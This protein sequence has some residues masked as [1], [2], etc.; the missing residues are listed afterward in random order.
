MLHETAHLHARFL[1]AQ[2]AAVHGHRH[3]HLRSRTGWLG[4]GC[5]NLG[6]QTP[7]VRLHASVI[8][9]DVCA[10]LLVLLLTLALTI[11]A[12]L[13]ARTETREAFP[14][15]HSYLKTLGLDKLTLNKK[16]LLTKFLRSIQKSWTSNDNIQTTYKSSWR[17]SNAR[18]LSMG[19]VLSLVARFG[20]PT[21]RTVDGC[22]NWMVASGSDFRLRFFS[23]PANR[24]L[25][26]KTGK[27]LT[28]AFYW[29]PKFSRSC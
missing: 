17:K 28:K 22:V 27:T 29:K 16:S 26:L 1:L 20:S 11:L 7:A 24:L 21:G 4:V 5:L 6:G 3:R 14:G 8:A 2:R 25:K 10:H 9:I 15:D 13:L 19:S 23:G 12:R 18:D